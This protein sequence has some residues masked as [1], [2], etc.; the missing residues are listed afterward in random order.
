MVT[1]LGYWLTSRSSAKPWFGATVLLHAQ[2]VLGSAGSDLRRQISTS[3]R[4][5][6]FTQCVGFGVPRSRGPGFG[7]PRL[8]GLER[9]DEFHESLAKEDGDSQRS[10]LGVDY[11]P[12]T[13]GAGTAGPR[14]A[15]DASPHRCGRAGPLGRPSALLNQANGN[16]TPGG[17]APTTDYG[18]RGRSKGEPLVGG[19]YHCPRRGQ[20]RKLS[21]PTG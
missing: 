20:S 7:V 18:T 12:G 1:A 9:R 19:Q 15:R 6:A 8:V 17:R 3:I 16:D 11:P 21:G 2:P 13:A 14:L 10:S 4:S 5:S